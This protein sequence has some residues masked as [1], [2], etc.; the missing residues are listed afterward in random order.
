M[1]AL[2]LIVAV[3]APPQVVQV[4]RERLRTGAERAYSQVETAAVRSCATLGAPHP[5][6]GLEAWQGAKEAWFLNFYASQ[7]EMQDVAR[8]YAANA[9][10]TK[11]LADA[12]ARKKELVEPAIT[13][14]ARLR[15]SL[16][17]SSWRLPGARFITVVERKNVSRRVPGVVFATATGS[18]LI[19]VP[20]AT[21][22]DAQQ[23]A[24]ALGRDARVFAIRPEW[25][26]PAPEWVAADPEFWK[27]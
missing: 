19:L 7:A 1:L 14:V 15:S 22:L 12:A 24:R 6:L 25:S 21:R 27:P 18:F 2:S 8:R 13:A 23:A 16:T 3:A 11:A 17:N 10:L 26:L 5:F 9:E 4:Y 20:G